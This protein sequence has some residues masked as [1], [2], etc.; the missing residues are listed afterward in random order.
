MQ[1]QEKESSVG[2]VE[3]PRIAKKDSIDEIKSLGIF[4]KPKEVKPDEIDAL[5]QDME[6]VISKTPVAVISEN[7]SSNKFDVASIEDQVEDGWADD[8]DD[9][10]AVSDDNFES[11]SDK[12]QEPS[13]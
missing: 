11:I 5:F 3:K 7:G 9:W 10:G 2:V 12:I 13:S 6:P 8:I 4:V 1:P